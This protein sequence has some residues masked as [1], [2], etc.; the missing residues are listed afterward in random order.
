MNQR[1][2]TPAKPS[3]PAPAHAQ[4]AKR[5]ADASRQE[6]LTAVVG[7]PVNSLLPPTTLVAAKVRPGQGQRQTQIKDEDQARA[8]LTQWLLESLAPA[9]GL[10]VQQIQ[11]HIDQ[12]AEDKL[13]P[14]QA[15]GMVEDGKIY[16]HPAKF[17][18]QHSAGR[19]L[20]VHELSHLA[21]QNLPVLHGVDQL[22]RQH[23]E[24]EAHVIAS[25]FA[26]QA[27]RP[28]Q[29][30]AWLPANDVALDDQFDFRAEQEKVFV[31]LRQQVETGRR[32]EIDLISKYL[33][34]WWVSDG[35]IDK[36]IAIL[37][38]MPFAAI[39]AVVQ[40][41][42]E[43][44]KAKLADNFSPCHVF[45]N[46]RV[47]IACW[48]G[49]S[50]F[51]DAKD[52]TD[53][54]DMV[55]FDCFRALDDGGLSTE[56]AESAAAIISALREN[57]RMRLL[58]G[59]NSRAIARMTRVPR[60]SEKDAKSLVERSKAALTAESG[61]AEKQ[62][63]VAA[64]RNDPSTKNIVDEVMALLTPPSGEH[65]S[66]TN[67]VSR[68]LLALDRLG[69][70]DDNVLQAAAE[71]LDTAGYLTTLFEIIPVGQYFAP[72]KRGQTLTTLCS[73]RLPSKNA[74]LIENLL[75]YGAFDW[76]IRDNEALL[77]YRIVKNLPLVEQY[78]FRQKDGGKWYF[79]LLD[80]LPKDKVPHPDLEVRK[81]GSKEELEKLRASFKKFAL[82]KS[83]AE[84]SELATEVTGDQQ[85]FYS[86]SQL[87]QR[88]LEN[89]DASDA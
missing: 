49:L 79:R 55:D 89:A 62:K 83:E 58:T 74:E 30:L 29:P 27:L 50:Q 44:L 1:A 24:S 61:L 45:K 60:L 87:Y 37:D 47:V 7:A 78:H 2:P 25:R 5:G 71:K 21:Q 46:Q 43:N 9:L 56:E 72:E 65:D 28:V 66:H 41:L 8:M 48:A 82:S 73:A 64:V 52:K 4:P 38:F 17:Q 81:A 3:L 32:R 23:A 11:I 12:E 75:S 84:G 40:V 63:Q 76:A 33:D 34:S 86:A 57:K 14:R 31:D 15:G 22:A 18:P 69:E 35:D 42:P 6:S 20:L 68:A 51:R 36:I 85:F 39:A 53:Y 80:N 19:Y 54:L 77:A 13:A 70:Q 59:S 88:R 67:D 26:Y 10:R 16:L